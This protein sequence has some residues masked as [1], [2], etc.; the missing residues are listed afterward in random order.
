MLENKPLDWLETELINCRAHISKKEEELQGLNH[1]ELSLTTAI[2]KVK[3]KQ[4]NEQ[5]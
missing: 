2:R 3:E 1:Y 5:I 4:K